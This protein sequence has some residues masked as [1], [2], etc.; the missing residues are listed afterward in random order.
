EL[1]L[2]LLGF[3]FVDLPLDRDEMLEGALRLVEQD[4][5][6]QAPVLVHVPGFVVL[7][8]DVDALTIGHLCE[9]VLGKD[10]V[11]GLGHRSKGARVGHNVQDA[12]DHG[13]QQHRGADRPA[14]EQTLAGT[15]GGRPAGPG[16]SARRHMTGRELAGWKLSWRLTGP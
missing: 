8:G 16:G 5:A 1:L 13:D 9:D 7:P 15:T 4:R 10:L 6:V 12:A 3:R 14:D 11:T 2:E